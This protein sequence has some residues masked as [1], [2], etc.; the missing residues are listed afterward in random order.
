MNVKICGITNLQDALDAVELG[1]Y[2]LGF[3]FVKSSPR[4]ITPGSAKEI[5]SKLPSTVK[6][7]GVFANTPQNYILRI[8]KQVGI[9]CIQLHGNE[10]PQE[11]S[12]YPVPIFK[13]FRVVNNFDVSILQQYPASAFLLDTFVE[14]ALGGTGKT[15]DWKIAIAAKAYGQI[16]LAGGLTPDNIAEAVR[17]VKPYAVDINSGVESAPGK[18]DKHKL[19]KLF[20]N[21]RQFGS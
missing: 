5:I 20:N 10:L 17:I 12:G 11:L 2:A 18:K 15:F 14:G 6:A 9:N 8:I 16:I 3:I 13:S 19:Q 7:I 21:L 1:A 4:Y